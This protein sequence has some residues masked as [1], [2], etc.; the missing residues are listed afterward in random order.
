MITAIDTNVLI[1]VLRVEGDQRAMSMLH[2]QVAAQ[3]GPLII[4][5][6]VFAELGAGLP[7]PESPGAFL[8]DFGIDLVPSSPT[9]LHRA[10]LAWRDYFRQR[11]PGVTC[12]QCGTVQSRTCSEC[13]SLIRVRQHLMADFLIGAH[14]LVHADRLL[15][16]D[17]RYYASFFP[18]LVL[19]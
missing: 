19:A 9:A 11:G 8:D 2:V 1:D 17:R 12:P 5:E 18:E 13:G 6:V 3:Q 14:A 16:R 7:S 10:G 4:S 15:T